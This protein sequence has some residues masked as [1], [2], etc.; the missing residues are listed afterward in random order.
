MDKRAGPLTKRP[1]YPLS[2]VVGYEDAKKALLCALASDEVR[3][4]L[5]KGPAGTAKSTLARGLDGLREGAG[6]VN[7]P[8]GISEEQLAGGLDL[9]STLA[10]G[11]VTMSP[12]LL[13]RAHGQILYVDEVNLLPERVIHQVLDEPFWSEGERPAV[14]S[15]KRQYLVVGTMDPTEGELSPHILDRF[16]LCIEMSGGLDLSQRKEVVRRRLRYESDP[17]G[18]AA[19]FGRNEEDMRR[20]VMA[21]RERVPYTSMAPGI[22]E[23]VS[24]LVRD[25]GCEGSRGDI[26]VVRAALAYAAFDGRDQATMDDVREVA[27]LCLDHRRRCQDERPANAPEEG[28]RERG[29][30]QGNASSGDDRLGSEAPADDAGGEERRSGGREAPDQIFSVG[31]PLPVANLLTGRSRPKPDEGV[32]RSGR[33]DQAISASS[34]RYSTSRTPRGRPR[35]LALDATIR[36]AAPYQRSRRRDGMAIVIHGSDVREK[37]RT[38]R[39]GTRILFLV[40]ASGSMGARQRMIMVKGM[41]FSMLEDAYRKRDLIG[42]MT[43][44]KDTADLLLPM[45]KSGSLAFERLREIPTGGR[46]PLA[47]GLLEAYRSLGPPGPKDGRDS[48]V[49]VVLTDGRANVPIRGGDPFKEAMEV[50]SLILSAGIRAVVI[51]TGSGYP[52]IDRAERL[53]G[54]LGARYF[55]LEELSSQ[56]LAESVNR[57]VFG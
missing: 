29:D 22:V 18:F 48:T 56:G 38:R 44:R 23:V 46:T 40:D 30:Q 27:G 35:D 33:R 42:L 9:E 52:R 28:P 50:A 51:D 14:R 39:R 11:A 37:V 45:T 49:L 16:D 1:A 5:V 6:L 55:R 8:L 53:S 2:A 24:Q 32:V 19:A 25:L 20:R 3:A 41:V 26:S 7:V 31:P 54:A 4:V 36:A 15:A 13:E 34:G 21:A 12:G 43:F 17:E 10:R 57:A 47:K